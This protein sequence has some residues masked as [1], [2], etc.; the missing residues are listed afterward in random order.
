MTLKFEVRIFADEN[1]GNFADP[2]APMIDLGMLTEE[3][4]GGIMDIAARKGYW[5]LAKPT[6]I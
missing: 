2:E 4:L 1:L 3:E 5:V 6:S